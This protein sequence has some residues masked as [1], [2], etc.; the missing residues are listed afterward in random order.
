MS[1]TEQYKEI[2]QRVA[3]TEK[4]DKRL[5]KKRGKEKH[6]VMY[7]TISYELKRQCHRINGK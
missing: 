4:R 5:G 7:T 2:R 3:K 1:D 6:A